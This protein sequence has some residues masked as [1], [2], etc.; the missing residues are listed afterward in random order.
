[1]PGFSKNRWYRP[2]LAAALAVISLLAL[3]LSVPGLL[4][5]WVPDLKGRTL[6][7]GPRLVLDVDIASL[8]EPLRRAI[9]FELRDRKINIVR[10]PQ[11]SAAGVDIFVRDADR[12]SALQ[13]LSTLFDPSA[14][15][16]I[17]NGEAGSIRIAYDE[18]KLAK[19]LDQAA[20]ASADIIEARLSTIGG[21]RWSN[22][23][24]YR[25]SVR[26]QQ[27]GRIVVRISQADDLDHLTELVTK[28]GR[29]EFRLVNTA[30]KPEQ[31]LA[32]GAPPNSDLLYERRKEG[33]KRF[34]VDARVI[35]SGRDIE[36]VEPEV[37]AG[38]HVVS[39]RL[40]TEGAVQFG[41]ATSENVGRPFAIVL[42]NEVV[43]APVIR[44]P[45]TGGSGQI[46]G[47]F[48]AQGANEFAALVRAGPLPV[49]LRVIERRPAL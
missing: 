2:A 36:K 45:V 7:S 39:F 47:D 46:S 9:L 48:S 14:G 27:A 12:T 25:L 28:P 34:V 23:G 31:A 37:N 44:Q 18:A 29:L 17:S 1:M 43:S 8:N 49:K 11:V 22:P 5:D 24:G 6:T 16:A 26:P 35:V 19:Q 21:L 10:V 13:R 32:S 4:P 15:F 20:A 42:D 30:V 40:K 38:Q 41:R 33:G 3:L